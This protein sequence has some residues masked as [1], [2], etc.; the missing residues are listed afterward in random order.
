MIC[1]DANC[2][3]GSENGGYSMTSRI[4]RKIVCLQEL[5]EYGYGERETMSVVP[6]IS[7]GSKEF[8]TD[9]KDGSKTL[10]VFSRCKLETLM[11][12]ARPI[13]F[14]GQLTLH[15]FWL[16]RSEKVERCAVERF[17]FCWNCT[18]T[19]YVLSKPSISSDSSCY[20]RR[21]DS[22]LFRMFW[23]WLGTGS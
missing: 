19:F 20:K 12:F 6:V 2:A 3:S 8:W 5:S 22:S 18:M 4:C 10:K 1:W 9:V 14:A 15:G 13:S 21:S 17:C 7:D 11:Q 23:L 16:I